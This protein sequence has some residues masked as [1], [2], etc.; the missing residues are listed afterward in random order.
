M[1]P[2]RPTVDDYVISTSTMCGSYAASSSAL[3]FWVANSD[4]T[5]CVKTHLDCNIIERRLVRKSKIQNLLVGYNYDRTTSVME[6]TR[7]AGNFLVDSYQTSS[8]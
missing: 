3:A 5:N 2:E 1:E 8:G 4:W 7:R 6:I